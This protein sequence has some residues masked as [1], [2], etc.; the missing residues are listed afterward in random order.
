MNL[1]S[2]IFATTLAFSYQA[3]ATALCSNNVLG[4]GVVEMLDT[5]HL[6]LTNFNNQTIQNGTFQCQVTSQ[7]PVF[8][9]VQKT[10]LCKKLNGETITG[11]TI[12]GLNAFGLYS[13]TLSLYKNN[14]KI[15]M[16]SC[17]R[18]N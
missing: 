2:L 8:F 15:F 6:I 18:S 11:V 12:E 9:N 5:P 3:A 4:A 13:A 10:I 1:P 14:T 16:S 17:A 7:I